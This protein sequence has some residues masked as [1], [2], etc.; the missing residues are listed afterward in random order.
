MTAPARRPFGPS[1][2]RPLLQ[3]SPPVRSASVGVSSR[4]HAGNQLHQGYER[5]NADTRRKHRAGRWA[6]AV[7]AIAVSHPC[8]QP[9]TSLAERV[10]SGRQR[11]AALDA[12]SRTSTT[13]RV[14]L[15]HWSLCVITLLLPSSSSR[16]A[17]EIHNVLTVLRLNSQSGGGHNSGSVAQ[18]E[19]EGT[20][21]SKGARRWS[22]MRSCCRLQLS[23]ILPCGSHCCCYCCLVVR[24]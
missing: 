13:R 17:G 1:I 12:G 11:G 5:H 8:W 4:I 14:W 19:V 18:M 10:C 9:A 21:A 7:A 6:S 15:A 2:R 23:L 20:H 16:H 24:M 3:S 22:W